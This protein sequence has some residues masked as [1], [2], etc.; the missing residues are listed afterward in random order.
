MSVWWPAIGQD[1]QQIVSS[2]NDC[3]ESR[4]TQRKEPLLTTPLPARPWERVG[5]DISLLSYR[6]TPL[7]ATGASPAQL[8][9]GRQIRTPIPTL[10]SNLQPAWPDLHKVKQAD[11]KAKASYRRNF[12]KRHNVK[13]L[14]EL[15][16][17][18]TV[19]LKLDSEQ[20]WRKCGKVLKMCETPRSYLIQTETGVL[21]RNRHHL[22]PKVDQDDGPGAPEQDAPAVP[23]QPTPVLDAQADTQLHQSPDPQPP[24][25]EA[26]PTPEKTHRGRAVKP[27]ERYKD[28]VQY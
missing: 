8:I 28:F 17:G 23:E 15:S 11:A 27:P 6:S 10:E 3:R 5:A 20:G 1:I 16:P 19:A 12:N 4:P 2:C 26:A 7:Q 21:R 25:A 14:P 24:A 9:M 22:M 18:T 13:D